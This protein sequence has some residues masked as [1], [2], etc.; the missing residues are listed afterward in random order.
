MK[1]YFL[2]IFISAFSF[3]SIATLIK[4]KSNL[5]LKDKIIDDN[6]YDYVEG[7]IGPSCI[8]SPRSLQENKLINNFKLEIKNSRKWY[9]NLYGAYTNTSN[10]LGP[11]FKTRL[12]GT[13]TFQNDKYTCTYQA[14]IRMHGD[15][16]DHLEMK[17]GHIFSSLDVEL[18]DGNLNGIRDFKLFLL[19][20]RNGLAEIKVTNLFS[21]I[22]LLSPRTRLVNVSIN[23][24]EKIKMIF[25]EKFT[26]EFMEYN[27]LRES[28]I[29]ESDESIYY[30]YHLSGL[31]EKSYLS[32]IIF[33][34][35]TNWKWIKKGNI[36][37]KISLK[38]LELFSKAIVDNPYPLGFET[39]DN[40][41]LRGSGDDL[42]SKQLSLFTT[43]KVITGSGHGLNNHNRKFYYE[44]FQNALLPIYYDGNSL[45]G[46][47]SK[48]F[49]ENYDYSNMLNKE[50]L[51]IARNAIEN[52]DLISLRKRFHDSGLKMNKYEM[53]LLKKE[54]IQN[55][56]YLESKPREDT[57]DKVNIV[58]DNSPIDFG[59]L[60]LND[61]KKANACDISFKNCIELS[62]DSSDYVDI[63]SGKFSY[64]KK[65]Y[66][67]KFRKIEDYFLK[68]SLEPV[69][70]RYNDIRINKDINIRS[71]GNPYIDI[72]EKAKKIIIKFS[73]VHQK[74]VIFN[75]VLDNWSIYAEGTSKPVENLNSSS[76]FDTNLLTSLLTIQDSILNNAYVE[77]NNGYSEDSLNVIRSSG[78]FSKIKIT[79][80]FQD[81]VDFDFSSLIVERLLVNN[82]GNDC[83]DLSYGSY[84]FNKVFLDGCSDKAI[85]VGESSVAN[86]NNVNIKKANLG[87]VSKDSS[88]LKVRNAKFYDVLTC[89]SAY[90]KK[91]EFDGGYIEMP[92]ESCGELPIKTQINSSIIF[93]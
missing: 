6:K 37:A 90:R 49:L 61:I 76:R 38:A 72:N 82:S 77:I 86:V 5:F 46:H 73:S 7:S 88:F 71:Y 66:F 83:L 9:K 28:A 64:N 70:D 62:L 55:I 79:N 27:D 53:N 36:N 50:D 93:K 69:E 92:L 2:F 12:R 39:F 33:P 59:Y 44:P 29:L 60:F 23:D 68:D 89:A 85:S 65:R 48:N 57:Q 43:L 87:L 15:A 11:N 17:D 26:K 14:K 75:S 30:D 16:K 22:G 84:S 10:N 40:N 63:A 34:K 45:L 52:L 41:I 32:P 18:I 20:A 21:E 91:P 58:L 31:G 13:L 4:S 42:V 1:K 8:I 80:S 51:I 56:E 67:Y 54:L 78:I 25:Q 24:S 3:L 81:S 19:G 74:V 35:V 47:P